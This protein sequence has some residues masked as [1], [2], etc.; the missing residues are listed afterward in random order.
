M[1]I[2]RVPIGGTLPKGRY[3]VDAW[4]SWVPTFEKWIEKN[5]PNVRVTSTQV[6]EGATT[7]DGTS[8]TMTLFAFET[9]RDLPWEGPNFPHIIPAGQVVTSTDDIYQVPKVPD[10]LDQIYQGFSGLPRWGLWAGT[11]AA[12]ALVAWLAF[13]AGRRKKS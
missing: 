5:T 13:A 8:P 11:G 6:T 1:P 9:S 7:L 4:A 12:A 2:L 10:V 3:Y